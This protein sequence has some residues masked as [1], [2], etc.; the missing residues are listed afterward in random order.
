MSMIVSNNG[1]KIDN[2]L[3]LLIH[4]I[5]LLYNTNSFFIT[6]NTTVGSLLML[7]GVLL[8]FSRNKWTLDRFIAQVMAFIIVSCLLSL[9]FNGAINSLGTTI[10]FI[11]IIFYAVLLSRYVRIEQL[12]DITIKTLAVLTCI[13]LVPHILINYLGMS[14][15]LNY[16]P[17]I[18]NVNGS[19]IY[20]G[21]LFNTYTYRQDRC[22][23]I[24]WEP[25][26]YAS[27]CTLGIAFELLLR[28]KKRW[29]LIAICAIGVIISRSTGGYLVLL[30][31]FLLVVDSLLAKK[32]VKI[33]FQLVLLV[34]LIV[35][36]IIIFLNI[37]KLT[38]LLYQINPDIFYKL[39]Q[40]NNSGSLLTRENSA[41]INLKLFLDKPI[42]GYGY[43]NV[44]GYYVALGGKNE[45]STLTY[46]LAA[47]GV[48]GAI[49]TFMWIYGI[50][51]Q[52]YFTITSRIIFL[53]L[54]ALVL[55]KEP[56]YSSCF[57]Y[58]LL[59]CLLR[60]TAEISNNM[61]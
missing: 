34:P 1:L 52:K 51:K 35:L 60:Y 29:L 7:L 17:I 28:E 4:V 16:L 30:T 46:Y 53:A 8:L 56:Y 9:V 32:N 36:S 12:G 6:V 21:F 41:L 43:G 20:C 54:I 14:A 10:R 13:A 33:G 45:T 3:V 19:S 61:E 23:S 11:L 37:D 2:K 58:L 39:L 55:L 5:I 47:F 26:I 59:F 40:E 57:M 31:C 15:F 27:F 38:L 44:D 49:Y 50:I 22:M 24:F 25:A 42:F 18:K 48:W